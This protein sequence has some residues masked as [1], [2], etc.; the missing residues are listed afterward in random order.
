MNRAIAAVYAISIRH[1]SEADKPYTE[2]Q[3]QGLIDCIPELI[4][5]VQAYDEIRQDPWIRAYLQ[6][7]SDAGF[8]PTLG[9]DGGP[10]A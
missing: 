4:R 6:A 5:L 2:A 9:K 10:G 3:K 7:K 1:E 8:V